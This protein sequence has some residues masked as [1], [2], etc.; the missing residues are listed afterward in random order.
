MTGSSLGLVF[1]CCSPLVSISLSFLVSISLSLPCCTPPNPI[2]LDGLTEH[3]ALWHLPQAPAFLGIFYT[4]N[5]GIAGG[6]GE[7]DDMQQR[8]ERS[9]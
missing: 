1:P 6:E 7:T 5:W 3:S 9:F 8:K 4:W 2:S